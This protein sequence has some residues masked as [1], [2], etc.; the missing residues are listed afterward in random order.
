VYEAWA[1]VQRATSGAYAL[2]APGDGSYAGDVQ[3]RTPCPRCGSSERELIRPGV[4]RCSRSYVLEGGLVNGPGGAPPHF[5]APVLHV[6]AVTRRS[7][8]ECRPAYEELCADARR[9]Q[10]QLVV[11][12]EAH[13]AR[14]AEWLD[15]CREELAATVDPTARVVVVAAALRTYRQPPELGVLLLGALWQAGQRR[16]ADARPWDHDEVGAWFVRAGRATARPMSVGGYRRTFLGGTKYVQRTVR[17]WH[18]RDGGTGAQSGPSPAV[19]G[20]KTQIYL[21]MDGRRTVH[22]GLEDA[23]DYGFDYRAL[24]EMATL[25]KLKTLPEP[26]APL[27]P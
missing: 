5:G 13:W 9:L 14:W 10:D 23:D 26:P 6:G 2:I 21:H 22:G 4:W 20:F 18:F 27:A 12:Y 11:R 8:Q 3:L 16:G 24:A 19:P 1:R 17:G 15:V 7:S 25:A